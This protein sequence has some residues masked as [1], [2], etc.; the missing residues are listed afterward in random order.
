MAAQF[1]AKSMPAQPEPVPQPTAQSA[2]AQTEGLMMHAKTG[3][4]PA[5]S[6]AEQMFG[7]K[8]APD[9]SQWIEEAPSDLAQM[10]RDDSGMYDRTA[11]FGAVKVADL[12]E[13]FQD[14]LPPEA[15]AAAQVEVHHWFA[16][17]GLTPAEA[18]DLTTA[19][20]Q[21]MANPPDETGAEQMRA[22]AWKLLRENYGDHAETALLRAQALAQRDP[23]LVRM[24][25]QTGLGN[26]PAVV[27]KLAQQAYREQLRGR[28]KV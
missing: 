28:L 16:D 23:R 11:P 10:R 6:V 3:D 27:L 22:D 24:L 14:G 26:H 19:A 2:H 17:A 25:E 5:P 1:F 15:V 13:S 12:I 18:G 20:R 4:E 9:A 21:M 7:P 8:P